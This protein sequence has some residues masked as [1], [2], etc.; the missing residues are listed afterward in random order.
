MLVLK[1]AVVKFITAN[2]I[3]AMAQIFEAESQNHRMVGR[4]L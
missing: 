4:D 3:P 1:V 2:S